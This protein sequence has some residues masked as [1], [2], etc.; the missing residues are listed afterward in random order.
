MRALLSSSVLWR[1][2]GGFA[3]G[4]VLTLGCGLSSNPAPIA[5]G[6]GLEIVS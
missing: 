6:T 3:F 5:A 2:A 4:T 1:V